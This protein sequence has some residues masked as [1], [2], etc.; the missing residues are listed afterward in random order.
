LT[1][2]SGGTL[3]VFG[4]I[5]SNVGLD[6]GGTEFVESGGLTSGAPGSGT[7][8]SGGTLDVLSG[9]TAE[10][11]TVS[12]GLA[13][14]ESGGAADHFTISSGGLAIVSAGATADHLTVSSGGTLEVFG[15][16]TSNVGLDTGGT[17]FVE[18]GGLTS[19]APGSGTGISGGTLDVLSGGSPFP[20]ASRLSRRAAPRIISP[21]RAAVSRSSRRA[22][23]RII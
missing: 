13:I 2:S 4:T 10:F 14:V 23:L 15:T 18:S 6:T 8:I 7:G 12:S 9:G 22:P 16:I 21:F 19:G 3:K 17:E 11:F 1:V 5:T 20:A